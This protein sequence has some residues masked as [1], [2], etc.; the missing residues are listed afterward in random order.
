[1]KKRSQFARGLEDEFVV[2]LSNSGMAVIIKIARLC[3]LC[4][5]GGSDHLFLA[6]TLPERARFITENDLGRVPA[7]PILA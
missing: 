5:V 3:V 6:R 2:K 7:L 4:I 1:L